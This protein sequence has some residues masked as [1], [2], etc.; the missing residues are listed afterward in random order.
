MDDPFKIPAGSRVF[1]GAPANP[2]PETEIGFLRQLVSEQPEI[3]EAHFP[4]CYVELVTPAPC[5]VLFVLCESA[6][7][8]QTAVAT[9]NQQIAEAILPGGSV[10]IFPLTPGHEL[11]QP[12]RDSGCRLFKRAN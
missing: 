10:D 8:G 4:Q 5:Q 6:A 2:L 11:L 9:L 12:V 3:I 7:S 1:L